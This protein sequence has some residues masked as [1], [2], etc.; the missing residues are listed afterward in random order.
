[1]EAAA[2]TVPI[3]RHGKMVNQ[4]VLVEAVAAV[5]QATVAKG[6]L[7]LLAKV[8]RAA[9]V[10]MV[11]HMT[12]VAAVVLVQLVVMEHLHLVAQ[13]ELVYHQI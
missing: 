4:A 1:M 13:A 12:L 5:I 6:A 10:L 8:M 7:V 11:I 2:F 3:T 9:L